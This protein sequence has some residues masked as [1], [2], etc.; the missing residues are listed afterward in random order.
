MSVPKPTHGCSIVKCVSA[1]STSQFKAL[2]SNMLSSLSSV[3]CSQLCFHALT[4]HQ[5]KIAVLCVGDC[6]ICVLTGIYVVNKQVLKLVQQTK[7]MRKLSRR[8]ARKRM[9]SACRSSST[10]HQTHLRMMIYSKYIVLLRQ[11]EPAS[12]LVVTDVH[13]YTFV[14]KDRRQAK[15]CYKQ[16]RSERN[17]ETEKTSLFSACRIIH[18]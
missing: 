1:V 7:Q 15:R 5:I 16:V 14:R 17:R 8:G 13:A 10:A 18:L 11:S 4:S 3:W 12:S 9:L 2:V 6:C